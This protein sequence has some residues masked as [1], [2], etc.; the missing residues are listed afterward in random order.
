MLELVNKL[1]LHTNRSSDKHEHIAA[2]LKKLR[3]GRHSS[4]VDSIILSHLT[5]AS[6]KAIPSVDVLDY[7]L[8]LNLLSNSQVETLLAETLAEIRKERSPR[9]SD[10]R[11]N[12]KYSHLML[13]P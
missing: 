3:H 1:V 2:L 5:N 11:K 8:T 7:L 4:Y 9:Y 10:L 6:L 12:T 13:E